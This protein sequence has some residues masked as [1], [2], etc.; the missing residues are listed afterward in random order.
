[1]EAP[2][3]F[4]EGRS[5]ENGQDLTIGLEEELQI[6]DP[7]TLHLTNK[8]GELKK[9]VPADL[10]PWVKG[11]LIASEIEI[12]TV[13]S[14]DFSS[15]AGDFLS[16]H[17]QLVE[18]ALAHDLYLGATG[19]H[20]FSP[21]YD[22]EI[23]D[24]PHYRLVEGE[25][26]YVAWR[27]NTFSFHVHI[28]VKGRERAILVCD[29]LRTFLP[30]LLALSA[31]SPF[32]EGRYTYLH[33]VRTQLFAKNFPRC[34]LPDAFGSWA[35]Y[36]RYLEFLYRSNS[37]HEDT[38]IW[39]S[40]RPHLQWGTVEVRICD[41]QP[42]PE[43]TLKIASLV[44]ALAARVL[45]A[46]DRGEPLPVYPRCYLEEN[47]WRATRYGLGGLLVDL[48]TEREVPAVEA[49]RGLLAWTRPVHD[50]LCLKPYLEPLG[51]F[52][53]AGNWARRQIRAYEAGHDLVAIHRYLAGLTMGLA[54]AGTCG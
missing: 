33:S 52:M 22:Q 18:L 37:I 11:E 47:F 1:M 54:V 32:Y 8:F 2:E 21:W 48:E 26:R 35:S 3:A 43:D 7:R 28:G 46:V 5:F 13:R 41:A 38:Q 15:A 34:G 10:D 19:V 16:K 30:H 6:L 40:I 23:I 17:R 39:W 12:A 42:W 4:L 45:L 25:L 14:Q 36:R 53:A 50:E 31:S 49:I 20:P 27:N 24:T 44:V 29:A 9:A 51:E